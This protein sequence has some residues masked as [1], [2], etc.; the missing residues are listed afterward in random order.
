[1]ANLR[2]PLLRSFVSVIGH[3]GSDF[4]EAHGSAPMMAVLDIVSPSSQ[5]PHLDPANTLQVRQG[6][7]SEA[8]VLRR[9]EEVLSLERPKLVHGQAELPLAAGLSARRPASCSLETAC[10]ASAT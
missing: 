1:L 9:P 7:P 5:S 10:A 4:S 2:F 6:Q 3:N 8:K